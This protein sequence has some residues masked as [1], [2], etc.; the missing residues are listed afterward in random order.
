MELSLWHIVL[1]MIVVLLVFGAKRIPEIGSSLG[2]GI[3]E[4]KRSIKEIDSPPDQ[5][6]MTPPPP[7]SNST[8]PPAGG[9]PK[10]L[11]Q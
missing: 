10:R 2:Q 1:L 3:R 6:S 8:L 9:E 5:R 4:F 11:S 7:A